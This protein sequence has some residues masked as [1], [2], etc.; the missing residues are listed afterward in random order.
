MLTSILWPDELQFRMD[1]V[2]MENETVA[3]LVTCTNQHAVCPHCQTVSDRIHSYYHRHPAD[4]PFAGYTIGLDITVPRFFCD[5]HQCEAS[6]FAERMPAI[7]EPYAH[8]TNRLASQQQ[9]VAFALGGEAGASLLAFMGMAVS[10]DTLLRLIR[11]A[12]EPAVTTPRVLGVD[13]WSKRKGQSYGTILVDLEAHRPVDL[14]PDKSAESFAAWLKAHPGVEIISRDR[15][16]EY[17]KGATEGAPDAIQVADRW[18]LLKNIRESLERWLTNR[19]ACLKAAGESRQ[20]ETEHKELAINHVE[21]LKE[22]KKSEE[23]TKTTEEV[24]DAPAKLTKAE[25]Q[26]LERWEKRQE[27]FEAVKELYERGLS[28]SEISRRLKLDWRTVDKYIKADECPIY[29][30]SSSR[31]SKLDPYMDYM[32]QRWESGCHNATQI[33]REIQERG[34]DGA[35]RTVA[36]WA[37]KK[38]KSSQSSHSDAVFER[39]VRWTPRRASWLLVKQEDELIEEDRQAL[40]RMKQADEKVSEAYGLGQRFMEMVRERQPES[41]LTWLEDATK[42]GIDALKQFAKGI[43]QD[44][45]AVTNALLL[46][47]SN[48]QTEGQVNRLKLIKRQMYGRANFDLLRKRVLA[49]PL[50]C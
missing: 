38:R 34:F 11:S 35:R 8:R 4:L 33:W 44:L 1:E 7:L 27:R 6:T 20:D 9:Q 26:R 19:N 46:P 25:K 23:S 42:S 14:L 31:L 43:K 21:Q 29:S 50:R 30:G 5:N 37:T 18:H 45:D 28:K 13:E 32:R 40:E 16:K 3:I 12:P 24:P 15:G 2:E 47:W 10:P 22:L 39:L 48:G 41:L 36:E 17:I 49:R